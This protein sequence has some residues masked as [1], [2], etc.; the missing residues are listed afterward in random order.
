[1]VFLGGNF[2]N[3]CFFDDIFCLVS[4]IDEDV[5][6]FDVDYNDDIFI[7]DYAEFFIIDEL[8]GLL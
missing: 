8:G 6:F 5:L 2:M 7:D 4:S 3:N 1:M